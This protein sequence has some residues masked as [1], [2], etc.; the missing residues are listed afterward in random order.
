MSKEKVTVYDFK[1]FIY[2]YDANAYSFKGKSNFV[3]KRHLKQ[4]LKFVEQT[5]L[6]IPTTKQGKLCLKSQME[7][8]KDNATRYLR[9]DT[10]MTHRLDEIIRNYSSLALCLLSLSETKNIEV[11]DMDLMDI[12]FNKS[13][14]L[15][16]GLYYKY[17]RMSAETILKADGLIIDNI[18]N[19]KYKDSQEFVVLH[20]TPNTNTNIQENEAVATESIPNNQEASNDNVLDA[21]PNST[22][23]N[24]S[25]FDDFNL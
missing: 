19:P 7:N 22:E 4:Q 17:F 14:N 21:E 6:D 12:K 25:N 2:D 15:S 5:M 10:P 20:G 11:T 24:S 18:I 16:D 9:N 13:L 23:G 8:V 1:K 3:I